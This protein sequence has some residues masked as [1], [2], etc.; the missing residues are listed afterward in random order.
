MSHEV[1]QTCVK[2]GTSVTLNHVSDNR[3]T[4]VT[5]SNF[6]LHIGELRD[7]V[8]YISPKKSYILNKSLPFHL[9]SLAFER[10]NMDI[11]QPINL[12][13]L[14]ENG[15]ESSPFYRTLDVMESVDCFFFFM[16]GSDIVTSDEISSCD[17]LI[18]PQNLTQDQVLKDFL[19]KLK[20][21]FFILYAGTEINPTSG[22]EFPLFVGYLDQ[23]ATPN[24][25][26]SS[27]NC[28]V[29][30][31][32]MKKRFQATFDSL[33]SGLAIIN[34]DLLIVQTNRCWDQFYSDNG[35]E[36]NTFAVGGNY[37]TNFNHSDFLLRKNDKEALTLSIQNLY[38]DTIDEFEFEFSLSRGKMEHWFNVRLTQFHD[39]SQFLL[40]EHTLIDKRKLTETRLSLMANVFR[41]AK[42]GI[43]I[44]D[45]NGTILEVNDTFS[46][47]TGYSR[48]EAIG[49]NP[50]I[51]KSGRQSKE[52]YS[53]LWHD[54]SEKGHWY[55]EVWNRRKNGEVYAEMAT[56]SAVSDTDGMIQNYVAIFSDITWIKEHER[57]LKHIAHYDALT[58]LPNRLLLA[59]RL[60]QALEETQRR[61]NLL[62]IAY[63]DLD[64][65]KQLNDKFGHS[66]GDEI[67]IIV[68][69]RFQK[70][71]REFDTLA[72]IGGDEFIAVLTNLSEAH[73]S[74]V[75]LNQ[76]L[77]SANTPIILSGNEFN[78]SA[79]IGV[80][81]YPS[82]S[83]DGELLLRHA[84]QAMYLAKLAGKNCYHM[85]DVS[86]DLAIKTR[87]ET[88]NQIRKA[89]QAKEFV[90]YYQPKVEMTTG[91]VYG[92][93][94]LI[95]WLHP[96]R[97]LIPP[98]QF[99]PIIEDHDE[100]VVLGEWV[101]EEAL[102]QIRI[103]RKLGLNL[104]VSV[105]ISARQILEADFVNK[106]SNIL[107]KFPDVPAELIELEILETSALEDIAKVS[108]AMNACKK[109]GIHFSIDDFGTGYSSLTYL[110][111]LPANTL[112]IDQTFVKDMMQYPDDYTIV[113][114]I[115]GLALAFQRDVIAEGMEEP[116]LGKELI[117]L[118]CN[119][120][121]GYGIARPM[122]AAGFIPW[123]NSWT[124]D[125]TWNHGN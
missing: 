87:R 32:N 92:A 95:R 40:A 39:E 53:A 84:D 80:T 97:G 71:I 123:M 91:K 101:I 96:I 65:F 13:I 67:L 24:I 109:L 68:A 99:L 27:L 108:S 102:N 33:H 26:E 2:K 64:G 120:A 78:I 45:T 56:I 7:F 111:H 119:K 16:N 76:L 83:S 103:W 125:P 55:G 21:P 62:A 51:L 37:L 124:P 10:F 35:M 25:I 42:E 57:Q 112:K 113:R 1:E 52:F 106:L 81:I 79:S 66:I 38:D 46:D 31:Q 61:G 100:S 4:V 11:S 36:E 73:D 75:I 8:I 14:E 69:Q 22:I 70:S 9:V 54:I 110:K 5:R 93:E 47:I 117:R 60:S 6:V 58:G 63:I 18:V 49:K 122:P 29:R 48:E 107:N 3:F 44:T 72:R 85:F 17:F 104:I 121:Q 23:Q 115:V 12:G 118:G 30:N 41:N 59:D 43:F 114:G 74:E 98:I 34:R 94:A 89:I 90:L 86:M 50:R 105:N 77:T 15:K 82:D 28:A 20:K 19:Y 116:K 88:L